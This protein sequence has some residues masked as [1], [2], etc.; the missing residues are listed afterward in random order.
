MKINDVEGVAGVAHKDVARMKVAVPDPQILHPTNELPGL[1]EE[2]AGGLG[3]G[4]G[5][6]GRKSLREWARPREIA[7]NEP[8]PGDGLPPAGLGDG[9][10]DGGGNAKLPKTLQ[11]VP[12][13]LGAGTLEAATEPVPATCVS[14]DLDQKARGW[15]GAP[16]GRNMTDRANIIVSQDSRTRE[17]PHVGK[18]VENRLQLLLQGRLP[19]SPAMASDQ[20]LG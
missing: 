16:P 6:T 7:C 2:L 14:V 18:L 13:L 19:Q 17:S 5:R 8:A 15:R 11:R 9:Q 12:F 20:Q 3:E 10:R 4:S 1:H